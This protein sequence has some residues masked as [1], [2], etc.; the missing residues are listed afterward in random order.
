MKTNDGTLYGADRI[1]FFLEEDI[2]L[3]QV[4]EMDE[5]IKSPVHEDA[6]MVSDAP[7]F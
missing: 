2:S 3:L 7:P 4:T 1:V 5:H 6:Q